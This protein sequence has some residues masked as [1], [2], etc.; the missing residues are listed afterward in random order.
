LTTYAVSTTEQ[1]CAAVNDVVSQHR[2]IMIIA[3]PL[4][5]FSRGAALTRTF[6]KRDTKANHAAGRRLR[7]NDV[8]YVVDL[9]QP[10]GLNKSPAAAC[11][12]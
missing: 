11:Y 5:G 6:R 9:N 8:L 12:A 7:P 3:M 10:H 1:G 2:S 4:F